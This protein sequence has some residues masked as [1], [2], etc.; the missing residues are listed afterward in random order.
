VYVLAG[1]GGSGEVGFKPHA[2]WSAKFAKPRPNE[3]EWISRVSRW[4]REIIFVQQIVDANA[5]KGRA[6]ALRI[7]LKRVKLKPKAKG[8]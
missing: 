3:G 5:V 6:W 1:E 4:Q 8:K 2:P 7:S